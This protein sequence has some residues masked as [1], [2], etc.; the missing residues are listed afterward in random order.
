MAHTSSVKIPLYI[1][2]FLSTWNSRVFEFGAVLYLATIYPGTLLPMSIYARYSLLTFCYRLT[3][4]SWPSSS[5]YDWI[6]QHF[7]RCGLSVVFFQG[8]HF[9]TDGMI[10]RSVKQWLSVGSESSDG[11]SAGNFRSDCQGL[12]SL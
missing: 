4:K 1:S 5:D 12:L 8:T 9:P 10:D 7:K 3:I 6:A 2:H 11:S